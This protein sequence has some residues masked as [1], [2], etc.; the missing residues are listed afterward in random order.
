MFK[1]SASSMDIL[2]TVDDDI[3]DVFLAAIG[4]SPIDF[5][6]PSPSGGFRTPEMQNGLYVDGK[7]KA[8]GYDNL[9][10]HQS[11][12]ALDFYAY[13][14][15][16]ASWDKI[17]LAMI[18]AVILAEGKRRGVELTWGGTFGSDEFKGWDYPHIQ[19]AKRPVK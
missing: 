15:G 13:I 6:I 16:H 9:S 14:N 8:D 11:G 3:Q 10:Y 18:A 17:H 7:S 2:S 5:G 19:K 4:I 12:N 1:F